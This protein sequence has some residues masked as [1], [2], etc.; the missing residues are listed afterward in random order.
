MGDDRL[1]N[2]P[3]GYLRP[4]P[5]QYAWA[6]TP[7][8]QSGRTGGLEGPVGLALAG[9]GCLVG[10]PGEGWIHLGDDIHQYVLFVQ[11]HF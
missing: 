4:L 11:R 7:S 6:V 1:G 8:H 5:Y 2:E 3:Y 10:M 9:L